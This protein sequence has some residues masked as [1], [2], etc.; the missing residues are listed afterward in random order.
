MFLWVAIVVRNVREGLE[1]GD[2]IEELH[3]W[4]SALPEEL[5]DLYNVMISRMK[6]EYRKEAVWLFKIQLVEPDGVSE[7]CIDLLTLFCIE[8]QRKAGSRLLAFEPLEV[9]SLV[10]GCNDLK[11]RLL[12]RTAGLVQLN[13]NKSD[14]LASAT[15]QDPEFVKASG[16]AGTTIDFIHRTAYDYLNKSKPG[17]S[18]MNSETIPDDELY[19]YIAKGLLESINMLC[20]SF[21]PDIPDLSTLGALHHKVDGFFECLGSLEHTTNQAQTRLVKEFGKSLIW[22]RQHDEK[23]GFLMASRWNH[24]G[25]GIDFRLNALASHVGLDLYLSKELNLDEKRAVRSNPNDLTTLKNLQ[26][27]KDGEKC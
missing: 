26:L 2:T 4:I 22:A 16:C 20:H 19:F 1:N 10:N 13:E 9:S 14:I 25:F 5:E 15:Q 23:L 11:A 8:R 7:V 18:F 17:Q 24:S 21:P 12:S 3:Q 27:T 6:K